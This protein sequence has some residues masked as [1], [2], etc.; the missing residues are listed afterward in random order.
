MTG[1]QKPPILTFQKKKKSFALFKKKRYIFCSKFLS[2]TEYDLHS[3]KTEY[4]LHSNKRL[5]AFLKNFEI[6]G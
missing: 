6:S 2:G 5:H 3:N 4:D 1:L